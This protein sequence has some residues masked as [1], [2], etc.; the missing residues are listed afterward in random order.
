MLT[1][2]PPGTQMMERARTP[3]RWAARWFI[4]TAVICTAGTP[5]SA[6]IAPLKTVNVGKLPG[7][8][9]VNP[10]AHSA[11]V[12]NR[13]GNSV[14]V[15]D[16]ESLKVTRTIAVGSAPL[17]IA[18]N[19]PANMVYVANSGD[20]TISAI[21]GTSKAASSWSVGGQ[22]IALAVDSSLNRLYVADA[23]QNQIEILN[24]DNG[25][26]LATI[27][28]KLTPVA[29]ALNV[30]SHD[31]FVACTGRTGTMVVIDGVHAQVITTVKSLPA[32]I[33]SISVDPMTNVAVLVSPSANK[34]VAIDAANGYAVTTAS[35]DG[36]ADPDAT[37]Y[38]PADGGLFFFGDSG[39]GNVFFSLGDGGIH[40]GNAYAIPVIGT[41]ALA[42]NPN[43]NLMGVVLPASVEVVYLS[44]PNDP[45]IYHELSTGKKPAN[46]AFD[47]LSNR[48]FV[49]NA[50]SN[51]VSTFDVNPETV[52]AA[53]ECSCG[54]NNIDYNFEDTNPA[55]GTAYTLRLGNLY[56]INEAQAGAGTSGSSDGVTTIPLGSP[57]SGALAVNSATNKIYVGDGAGLFYSVNGHTNAATPIGSVPATADIRSLAVDSATNEI[58][59]WDYHSNM[60]DVLDSATDA[61]VHSIPLP[62]ASS[63][64]LVAVDSGKSL[65]YV[66]NNEVTV[67]DPAMGA[68]V[69][70]IPLGD[71]MST[72]LQMALDPAGNRLYVYSND[73][74]VYVI[75]TA[76]NTQVTSIS[77]A[78]VRVTSV[79]VNPLTGTWYVG[80]LNNGDNTTH[81]LVY[82][83]GSN[84]LKTDLSSANN[85][86]ITWPVSIFAN[87][88]TDTVYAGSESGTGT[89]A[90]A[91]IDG[92]TN[93][94]AALPSSS[95][96]KTARVLQVDLGSDVLAGA[97]Y[98]YT[99]LWF[100]GLSSGSPDLVP[101]TVAM[102]GIPDSGTIATGPIFRTHTTQPNF[103][104]T[105]TS[106]FP[107]SASAL[108]P[109]HAFYQVDGWQGK[110]I[111]AIL[112]TKSGSNKSRATIA[113]SSLS[114]GRHILYAYAVTGDVAT[115]QNSRVGGNSPV[116]SPIGATVFTI[117]R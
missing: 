90:G 62:T 108:V 110:W 18:A 22:P 61:L 66:A 65:A 41:G 24:A 77:P 12:V 8:M 82:D 44:A 36:A 53:A 35:G 56:A 93:V 99:N 27:P 55:T 81:V 58:V 60:I 96:E 70:T 39:D 72:A 115:I 117:E 7:Q 84:A 113:L 71:L 87:P 69:A 14:S 86:A 37:A 29:L 94:V 19:P 79:G 75:D 105:A 1:S 80:G 107:Q 20:G 5:V 48:L 64:A 3:T 45:S 30:A 83:G 15:V 17:A 74:K 103:T 111:V 9:V 67:I 100:P 109:A 88:L 91:A 102:K 59:A 51:T 63:T 6:A 98:S 85:P 34:Y 2:K 38:D 47:P 49:S 31:L 106:N 57:Y 68:V 43:V 4:A 78:G 10:A 21:A 16:T 95:S 40:L 46:L 104:I 13:G 26:L 76:H 11:F 52:T 114:T 101:I 42:L 54:G 23:T 92:R 50:G 116:I 89:T 97:G 33:S 73:N 25:T 112:K 32:D 28:T